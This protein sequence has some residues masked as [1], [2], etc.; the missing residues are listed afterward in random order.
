MQY[1]IHHLKTD[2]PFARMVDEQGSEVLVPSFEVSDGKIVPR[3][4]P[5]DFAPGV[6][7]TL[8]DIRH[9]AGNALR[10]ARNVLPSVEQYCHV[11]LFDK[12]PY[13]MGVVVDHRLLRVAA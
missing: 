10:A 9:H 8:G 1:T 11:L 7:V 5:A 12:N 2:L 13:M 4:I 6:P 3:K